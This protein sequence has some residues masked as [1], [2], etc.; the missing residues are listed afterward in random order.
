MIG[1]AVHCSSRLV[2]LTALAVASRWRLLAVARSGA[3]A[4]TLDS[5][6]LPHIQGAAE[7]YALIDRPGSCDRPDRDRRHRTGSHTNDG[8]R[9]EAGGPRAT[10]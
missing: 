8:D 9:L 3:S 10:P 6:V 4:A 2:A 5:S 7:C 1:A